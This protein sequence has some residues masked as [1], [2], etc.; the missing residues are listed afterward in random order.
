MREPPSFLS[1]RCHQLQVPLALPE[2]SLAEAPTEPIDTGPQQSKTDV[3]PSQV[4]TYARA[5]TF[6]R[7]ILRLAVWAGGVLL[8]GM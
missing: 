1:W 4:L 8:L 2:S 7:M 6:D 3:N 5:L